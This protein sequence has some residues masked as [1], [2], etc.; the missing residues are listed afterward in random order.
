MRKKELK[1][2]NYF[3]PTVECVLELQPVLPIMDSMG[4]HGD[5]KDDILDMTE[6]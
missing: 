4:G 6:Y 5:A 1:K 3:P 2:K